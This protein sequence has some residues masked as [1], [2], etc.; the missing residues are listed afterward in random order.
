MGQ[1]PNTSVSLIQALQSG[2]GGTRWNEFYSRYE[3][4]IRAY[5][6]SRFPSL[7]ADDVIQE[8]MT[9]LFQRLPN[10]RYVPDEKGHFRSYLLG[11]V[12]H[13][14]TDQIRRRMRQEKLRQNLPPPSCSDDEW[15]ASAL[16]V[17]ITQMMAD[18]SINPRNREVFRRVALARENPESVARLFGLDKNN[19]YQIKKRLTD[20]LGE[21]VK[22]MIGY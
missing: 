11:I 10:Y 9:A 19:V 15:K 18:D 5:L 6:A 20:N 3:S 4:V 12:H 14:A 21:R 16:E 1:I 8:T 7:E 22:Q 17:A 2:D 13:K